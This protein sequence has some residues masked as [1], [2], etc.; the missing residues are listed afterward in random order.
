MSVQSTQQETPEA[1]YEITLG[2]AQ[3][4]PQSPHV[5]DAP[6][7]EINVP[8]QQSNIPLILMGLSLLTVALIFS[9]TLRLGDR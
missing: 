1:R 8:S 3:M 4:E 5:I 2:P 6:A 7:L 9:G